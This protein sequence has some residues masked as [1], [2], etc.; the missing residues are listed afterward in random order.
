[1]I[2]KSFEVENNIQNALKFKFILIYGENIGL[3]DVLKKKIINSD[4][5]ADIVNL[6]QEDI[7]KNKDILL[8]EVKNI[9]LFKQKK[10]IILNQI[11]EKLFSEIDSLLDSKE[12]IRII[13]IGDI[14]DKKSK[15]R[16]LFEKGTS[17]A[18]IPC[19]NDND[20]TLKKLIQNELR[21]FKNVNSNIINMILNQSNLNRKTILN[22][23]EKIK[24]FYE[25]KIIS[26][27]NL[28]T[29]LNSDR[30]ELFENIRDAA[31]SGDKTKLNVLLNNFPFTNEDS[32]LY[33]NMINYRLIKLLEIH[34]ENTNNND[35]NTTINKIRPPIFWK[36]KPEFLKLMKKWDKQRLTGALKYLGQVEEKIKKNST[37]NNSTLVKNSITNICTNSWSYF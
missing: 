2:L 34:K 32:F 23:I 33:I 27:N 26:D 13:L 22:N 5:D 20:I 8:A 10:I 4:N 35:I 37:L 6:Y 9:S 15:L 11:N 25:N 19:Y 16:S 24:S 30:N 29:L 7:A 18:V 3:K 28:E 36:D 31:L 17:L 21:G 12:D 1:M 14:L